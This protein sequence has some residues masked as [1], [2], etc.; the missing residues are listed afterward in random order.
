MRKPWPVVAAIAA[1][2]FL[3]GFG[4]AKDGQIT[5]FAAASLTDALHDID[6]SYTKTSGFPVKESFASSS[7]LARQIEAGAPAQIFIS[8]DT[9]W[10]DYLVQKGLI[11]AQRPLLSNE[12]ALVAPVDSRIPPQAIDRGFDWLGRLGREGRLAVGDPD[13]VPAGIYAKEALQNLGA[14]QNVEPR[15]ARAEDVRGALAFV[16]RGDAPLGIVYI[17]DARISAKVKIV[18]VFPASS[19]SPIVYP[20]A[21]VKGGNSPP[22]QNYYRYLQSPQARGIFL[23]YGFKA[24]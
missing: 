19:H 4:E 20:A 15:L 12:L 8:A 9:K 2:V 24:R 7:T 1:L 22:V 6:Q 13:H 18:G 17:T 14:W 23:R 10:L 3:S 16:E 11:A 5:V 21:I